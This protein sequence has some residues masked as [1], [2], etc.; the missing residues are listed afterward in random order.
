MDDL[1]K[2]HD[3]TRVLYRFLLE[4]VS[5]FD[6]FKRLVALYPETLPSG[7]EPDFA[8]QIRALLRRRISQWL[9]RQVDAMTA[10]E[11]L[12]W[13]SIVVDG[14]FCQVAWLPKAYGIC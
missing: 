10:D 3:Q 1:P 8:V 4:R 14:H 12:C 6:E 9:G 11:L 2:V 13:R 5:N 7:G